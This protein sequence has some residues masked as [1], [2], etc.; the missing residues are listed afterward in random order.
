MFLYLNVKKNLLNI[1][2]YIHPS[3]MQWL[4]N[5]SV[6]FFDWSKICKAIAIIICI[7]KVE[8]ADKMGWQSNLAIEVAS[9]QNTT[10]PTTLW[11]ARRYICVLFSCVR[12]DDDYHCIHRTLL[13]FLFFAKRPLKV[14]VRW[15]VC[16]KRLSLVEAFVFFSRCEQTILVLLE[17]VFFCFFLMNILFVWYQQ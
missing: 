3:D 9:R 14:S 6:V 5:G 4:V 8:W 7:K 12:R 17:N 16:P 13:S 1:Q 11:P 15:S 10:G 2:E